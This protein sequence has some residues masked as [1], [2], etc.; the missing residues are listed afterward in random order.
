MSKGRIRHA[1][2]VDVH[3]RSRHRQSVLQGV[4]WGTHEAVVIVR[5]TAAA[6]RRVTIVV[7]DV[8]NIRVADIH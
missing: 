7:V 2:S 6:N 1:V 8:V 5:E 3:S 4:R